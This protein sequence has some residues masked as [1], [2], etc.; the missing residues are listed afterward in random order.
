MKIALISP[1]VLPIPASDGGAVETLIDMLIN[2]IG[3]NCPTVFVDVF[4]IDNEQVSKYSNIKY[5]RV[6]KQ[7]N[8]INKVLNK[9]SVFI[10]NKYFPQKF[11]LEV[12][13]IIRTKKYDSIIVENNLNII[14]Y[15]DD[16]K[17]ILH[18]HNNYLNINNPVSKNI[19][20][21]CTEIWTVSNFLKDEIIKIN[22]KYNKKVFVCDNGIKKTCES[23]N[24]IDLKK[25]VYIGRISE[26]K[27][28]Y[29]LIKAFKRHLYKYPEDEL[30][31]YGGSFFKNSKKNNYFK[32][33]EKEICNC[34][35]IK[36]MGYLPNHELLE[37]LK[38]YSFCIV[39]SIW[40]E[41]FGLVLIEQMF[42]GLIPIISN[43]SGLVEIIGSNYPLIACK[44]ENYIDNLT[45][46]LEKIK[47][48]SND[49]DF[50]NRYI[51]KREFC[52]NK[53]SYEMYC[54]RILERL[55]R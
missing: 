7:N 54:K 36:M 38:K 24:K 4:T 30:H 17:I 3:K 41:P 34:N 13:K 32:K 50:I 27:G 28:V 48:L 19:I 47:Q 14:E 40:E 55:I 1:G 20:N 39:P 22:P 26:E 9:I 37:E 8:F 31:I 52:S 15:L 45:I 51:E 2:Y 5:I 44:K 29:E 33:C 6:S 53:Y 46:M 42:S 43:S 23:L 21:K 49:T 12:L 16:N 18:L 35:N 11:D 25:Y 10:F